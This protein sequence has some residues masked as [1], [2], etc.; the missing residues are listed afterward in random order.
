MGEFVFQVF[1]VKRWAEVHKQDPFICPWGVEVLE[2]QVHSTDD[3]PT[4]LPGGQ[5]LGGLA[6]GP[7]MSFRWFSVGL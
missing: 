4:R 2:D 5:T 7:L 6:G 1:W 3:P